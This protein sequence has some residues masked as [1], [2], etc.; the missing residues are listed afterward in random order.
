MGEPSMLSGS[1]FQAPGACDRP[2]WG[3]WGLYPSILSPLPCSTPEPF[4]PHISRGSRWAQKS[5]WPFPAF[6]LREYSLLSAGG[7]EPG[8]LS[9]SQATSPQKEH[10]G[11]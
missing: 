11:R 3:P 8:R 4:L 7:P 5:R 9:L 2:A 10:A 6:Q 1:Q